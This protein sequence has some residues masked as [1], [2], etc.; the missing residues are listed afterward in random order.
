MDSAEQEWFGYGF[1]GR[2]HTAKEMR[3]NSS[4]TFASL[5]FGANG[6]GFQKTLASRL[7]ALFN[8]LPA[9]C[10]RAITDDRNALISEIVYARNRFAHGDYLRPRL[11]DDRPSRAVDQARDIAVLQPDTARLRNQGAWAAFK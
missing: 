2:G 5:S 10:Q 9:N 1:I 3:I 11:S 6:E 7:S 4:K 8:E